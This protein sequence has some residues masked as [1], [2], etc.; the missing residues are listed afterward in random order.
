MKRL[1]LAAAMAALIA[2]AGLAAQNAA[3]DDG[4]VIVT[5][6]RA[7]Q[8]SY[9]KYYDG[10]QSAIGLTRTADNFVKPI[11]INSD[12]RDPATRGS[13]VTAMLEATI[14]LAAREGIALVA[15]DFKLVPL[16]DETLKDLSYGTGT[17]PDTTRVKIYARLPVGGK[18][19]RVDEVDQ[20]I[21]AFVKT[22]PV[23]GRSYIETG[24]TDLAINNP[25]SYRGAVV[26]A[27]A[28]EAKRYA[29]M[30]GSDYG[31]EIRGLDSE[32]FFKQ[33]S[34]TEV[35]LFIEHNFVIRPK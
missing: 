27:I 30:F 13:E 32:L 20:A 2:P 1:V 15:G 9:D 7:G 3:Q 21:A 23:T 33:A 14:R 22:V 24:G 5:G 10:T 35:F 29:A 8:S 4:A 31:I 16:T 19:A 17:R 26:K 11:Y 34:G 6:S 12:S 25:Q 18:F 28:D